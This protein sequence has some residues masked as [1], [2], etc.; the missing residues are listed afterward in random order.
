MKFIA[1]IVAVLMSG[2]AF[3]Q[4]RCIIATSYLKIKKSEEKRV[5]KPIT[6]CWDDSWFGFTASEYGTRAFRITSLTNSNNDEGF[7]ESTFINSESGTNLEGD[8]HIQIV[9]GKKKTVLITFSRFGEALAVQADALNGSMALPSSKFIVQQMVDAKDKP[10]VNTGL[11]ASLLNSST[12]FTNKR[13]IIY[14]YAELM[15][16]YIGGPLAL[17]KYIQGRINSLETRPTHQT[18]FV[19]FLVDT[20]GIIRNIRL[21][22]FNNDENAT[23]QALKIVSEMPKWLPGKDKGKP[24]NVEYTIPIKF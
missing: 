6:I 20:S 22:G 8:Y 5:N 7:V 2:G 11:D 9:Y 18:I 19:N 17:D 21:K 12:D 24:V 1:L 14:T 4:M 15:P 13:M 10:P 3:A 16:E 23:R